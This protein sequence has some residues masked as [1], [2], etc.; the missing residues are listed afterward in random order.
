MPREF[1]VDGGVL[2]WQDGRTLADTVS[3]HA[4]LVD[5]GAWTGDLT[6]ANSYGAKQVTV[7]GVMGTVRA[8]ERHAWL[9]KEA[10]APTQGWEVY[11]TKVVQHQDEGLILLAN[12]TKLAAQDKLRT[13]IGLEQAPHWYAL[14]DFV[15]ACGEGRA[16]ACSLGDALAGTV[17][18][19][20]AGQAQKSGDP[21][22]VDAADWAL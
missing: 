2:H 11:A 19:I 7:H 6:L 12:A 3:L 1:R 18:A 16:P 21:V 15:A 4:P 17:L 5:G 22:A 10:D 8:A 13:G 14:D 20:R 9:F